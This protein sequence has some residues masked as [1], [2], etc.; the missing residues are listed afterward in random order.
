MFIEWTVDLVSTTALVAYAS[1]SAIALLGLILILRG[2]GR[3][4]WMGLLLIA[5]GSGATALLTLMSSKYWIERHQ[6]IAIPLKQFAITVGSV[7]LPFGLGIVLALGLGLWI[8]RQT[9]ASY[10]FLIVAGSLVFSLVVASIGTTQLIKLTQ[11]EQPK[12]YNPT[13]T[14]SRI[15]KGFSLTLFSQ[16]SFHLPTSLRFGPDGQLYVS[17]YNGDIWAIPIKDGVAGH[18][19]LFGSGF[20]DPVGLAWRGNELYVAS[21]GKISVL[22]DSEGTGSAD[23]TRDIVT[24]LPS[25]LYD[26]H[27]NYGPAFGPDGR[28]YFPLGATTDSSPETH[29]YAASILS[30]NPDGS[31]LRVFAT[32]VRNPYSLAFNSVG[33]LFATDNGPDNFTVTPG[34]ELN[35][36]V[37]GADYGFPRYFDFPLVGS[38]TRAPTALFP[39][40]AS[41]DGLAFYEGNQFPAEYKDNAFVPTFHRGEI[42]RVQLAKAPSGD[43]LANVSMFANGFSNPLDIA[44]GPDGSMYIADWGD[45]AIYRISY[46]K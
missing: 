34:D 16:E 22:R 45:S 31:D 33:D 11:D 19:R 2:H 20:L 40:H 27:S 36:I 44:M 32:G 25:R 1:Y 6:I 21:H 39:P 13:A 14:A 30:V 24:D 10:W 29:K 12:V 4:R 3:R 18:P 42:Y 41:A 9:K 46:S 5:A 17:D 15:E 8:V 38:G 23:Q 37:A 35:Y 28:L 43:Y 26:W 7:L